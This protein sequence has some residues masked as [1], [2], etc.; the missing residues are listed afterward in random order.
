[1]DDDD[2]DDNVRSF[3]FMPNGKKLFIPIMKCR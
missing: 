3:K 1:M 2:H